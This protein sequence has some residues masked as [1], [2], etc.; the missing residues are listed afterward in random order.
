MEKPRSYRQVKALLFAVWLAL[1]VG[2]YTNRQAL[3]DTWKLRGYTPPAEIVDVAARSSMTEK[4]RHLWYVNKPQILRGEGFTK[5][6]PIATEKTV[7]LGCYRGGDNGIFVYGVTDSRLQGVV[8]VTAAH[9]ML[10]AAYDRLS[11]SERSRVDRLT[12][13]FYRSSLNDDRVKATIELYRASDREAL[14]NE[15]HSIFAT[16]V[17]EL[18]AGLEKYYAQYFTNRAD[19]VALT[20]R[21]QSE[22]AS[23]R[24]KVADYDAQLRS[25][26]A[27]IE[28][29]QVTLAKLQEELLAEE[30]TLDRLRASDVAAYNLSIGEYN[31]VVNRYNVLLEDTRIQIDRYNETVETR[32]ELA[33][34]ERELAE[35][36]VAKPLPGVR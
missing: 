8:E 2:L 20:S 5:S 6:C 35:A 34:E 25:I 28:S 10:H 30:K 12:N 31:Q 7:V 29:S 17:N 33:L 23:R 13:D 11:N 18:P 36:L 15:M 9:E 1:L 32:N 21:Y 27:T 3:V 16:E 14:S 19:V 4:A 26:K 24:Q 22:F